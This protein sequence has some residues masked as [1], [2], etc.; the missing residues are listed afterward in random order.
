VETDDPSKLKDDELPAIKDIKSKFASSTEYQNALFHVIMENWA[1][2]KDTVCEDPKC[3]TEETLNWLGDPEATTVG[4][5]LKAEFVITKDARDCVPFSELKA[6][7]LNSG[8][9]GFSDTKLGREFN[10]LGLGS[11][12]RRYDTKVTK[13]RTGIRE[14]TDMEKDVEALADRG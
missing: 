5:I 11:D 2:I 8:L 1:E 10:A 6:Y 13:V 7:L 12:T 14:K 4:N 9:V 3:V